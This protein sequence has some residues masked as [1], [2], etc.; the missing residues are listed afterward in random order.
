MQKPSGPQYPE[1]LL[2]LASWVVVIAFM[3]IYWTQALSTATRQTQLAE[4]L[5]RRGIAQTSHALALQTETMLR[6]LDYVSEQLADDWLNK[7]HEAFRQAARHAQQA[8]PEGAIL[9]VGVSDAQGR[10][11]FSALD[12]RP[13]TAISAVSMADREY[14]QAHFQT[15]R[16][17]NHLHV[18]KPLLGRFSHEWAVVLSR[19]I[20]R[21]GERLGVLILSVSAKYLSRA[22]SQVYTD[23]QDAALIVRNDGSYIAR[24]HLI[25]QVLGKAV[26][27]DRD[28]LQRPQ[29]THGQYLITAPIDGVERYYAW[30][31]LPHYPLIVSVGISKAKALAPVTLAQQDAW[32]RNAIGSV[33]L[34]L[35]MLVVSHLRWK[36]ARQATQLRVA[37]E[38]M[39]L[40]LHSAHNGV[41]S[42]HG[43]GQAVEWD[44][45][46]CDMLEVPPADHQGVDGRRQTDWKA[47]VHPQDLPRLLQAWENYLTHPQDGVFA[48][49]VRMR[50]GSGGIKWV[51][52][53][54]RAVER[55]AAG[56]PAWVVGTYT[57]I[58]DRHAVDESLLIERKRLD[59]LLE[60]FPGGV[61][62]EDTADRVVLLNRVA[63]EWMGLS[64]PD[65]ALIGLTH[66]QLLQRLDPQRAAWLSAAHPQERRESGTTLEVEG[67]A[68]RVLEI[69][70]I[71]ISDSDEPLG[72]VWLLYDITERKRRERHLTALASTDS[73]TGL[74][75]RRSFMATLEHALGRA[76]S[77]PGTGCAVMMLDIDWFKQVND[78]HGHPVGDAVLQELAVRLRASLRQGDT[79]AR[80]GGEEFAIVLEEMAPADALNKANAIRE[81]IAAL[82]F[83]TTAGDI[84]VTASIGVA[85]ATGRLVASD[86][87]STADQALYQAKQEG[88][89]RVVL[90]RPTL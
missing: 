10:F 69:K 36:A 8:L 88:R 73:L 17:P 14:F 77:R 56:L 26:P 54:A 45:G 48:A 86:V 38:R 21:D 80:L 37:H 13:G 29:Q 89:N 22:L 34:V 39:H 32:R 31:R 2:L 40:T 79:A 16:S 25:D 90:W 81:R 33:V 46:L 61:L 53:R 64:V 59:V 5:A 19:P 57:D 35:M 12:P 70:R 11:I 7:P 23:P 84:R 24:S 4:D 68:G 65:K 42:W 9:N 27:L 76:Q 43:Q 15:P 30:H 85:L 66:E 44:G 6:K 58:T 51:A 60:R 71:E 74:P 82:P 52:V 20:D 3:A 55:D 63:M 28:F 72:R 75:N 62:M 67:P 49:E 87:L 1:Y 47:F 78:T 18:G 41:W 50:T 83:S